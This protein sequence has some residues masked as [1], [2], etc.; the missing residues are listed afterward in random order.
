MEQGFRPSREYE[1][2]MGRFRRHRRIALAAGLGAA[3]A[4]SLA[5]GAARAQHERVALGT[6]S[7]LPQWLAPG[8]RLVVRGTATPAEVVRL[9]VGTRRRKTTV[10]RGGRFVFRVRAPAESGRYRVFIELERAGV[11]RLELGSVKVRPLQIAAVGDVNLG[12]RVGT[13]IRTYGA[14][15]PWLSV[16]PVLRSPD[17]AIANLECS[18]STRGSPVPGKQYTFRGAP[19]SLRAMAA[20]AG[21][22]V[23]SVANNHSLDYGRVAFADTLAY[24]RRFGLR[25]VGGGRDLAA[26]RKPA[27]IERGGLRVAF[28]GYS[29]VR[30]LGFDAGPTWSGTAPAFP[31]YIAA[32]IRGA[33]NRGADVVVVYFHWGAERTYV[34]SGQQ[35]ALA[36]VAFDAGATVVLGAHPHVLQPRE[37]PRAR[38]LV[39]WSLGNFVFG[40]NSPGTASTGILRVRLGRAGVLGYAFRRAR[41]GGAFG[42]QPIL[43]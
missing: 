42:V 24:A 11:E 4:A 12:D 3:V 22:D 40:A 26:A 35:R 33:R 8:G 16:A 30:P 31:S 43:R 20:Y 36:G 14:R 2:D 39:A 10:G 5:W 6:T 18:V 13:A 9:Y 25:P 15:Y 1:R 38:R 21:I 19:S 41:I 32:D 28:F 7:T 29:D 37:Q 23:I 17:L 34:P 27:I